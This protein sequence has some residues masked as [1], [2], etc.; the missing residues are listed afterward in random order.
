MIEV[1]GYDVV[2]PLGTGGSGEV[3]LAQER[4]SADL[5]ALKILRAS[6]D[7]ARREA[8]LLTQISHDHIV[9]LRS[10]VPTPDGLVLVLDHAAGGSL[11]ELLEAR[12]RLAPGEV[13]TFAVPI[14]Q[15][16]AEIHARGLV[17]GDVAPGNVL[18]TAEGR[19]LLADLGF[20]RL[21]GEMLPHVGATPD[22]ADPAIA[23]GGRPDPASDVYG[24][25]AICHAALVGV[26][27]CGV[28]LRTG[29]PHVPVALADLV[30]AAL[31]PDRAARPPADL[32]AMLL[33]EACTPSPIQLAQAPPGIGSSAL[34]THRVASAPPR[35]PKPESAPGHDGLVSRIK[36]I[37]GRLR[38]RVSPVAAL[39]V[40]SAAVAA[41]LLLVAVVVGLWWAGRDAPDAGTIR[42]PKTTVAPQW[43]DV[44][45]SLDALRSRA[46]MEGDA[47]VLEEVYFPGSSLLAAE[48]EKLAALKAAG[49]H[50]EGLGLHLLD[51]RQETLAPDRAVL[52]VVDELPGYRLV[53][54]AGA[55][56]QRAGR[57]RVTW[58]VTLKPLPGE[59]EQWRIA[60]IVRL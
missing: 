25:G 39:R 11:A 46:F 41:L 28:L 55:V 54:A 14:A 40:I 52:T 32:I 22:F 17:H 4:E 38:T 37:W 10:T 35:G 44:L 16:L 56:E 19:P 42:A 34:V 8:A 20:S 45:E 2:S 30:D 58:R 12:G 1:P 33:L 60:E 26:P 31:A 51:V 50:A 24:L 48:Q 49:A 6:N 3:W 5:V 36:E 15:A 43:R 29:A 23:A 53:D 59:G 13:V 27:P 57:G 18:F 7:E 9:R 47:A 21:A